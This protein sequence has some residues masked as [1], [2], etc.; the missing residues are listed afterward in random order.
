M[1]TVVCL[2]VGAANGRGA[3][4]S[5][6][7]ARRARAELGPEVWSEVIRIENAAHGSAYPRM[8]HALVFELAD[9]L[10][11]Y[12]S[13]DGTQSL[14]LRRGQVAEDKTNLTPLLHAIERGFAR[15]TIVPDEFSPRPPEWRGELPNGCF[16]ESVAALRTR[17]ERGETVA[18]AQLLSYYIDTGDGPH[19]HTVLTYAQGRAIEVID[20]AEPGPARQFPPAVA[21][22]A[23][24]LARALA[25]EQV[26]KARWLSLDRVA[27]SGG[28]FAAGGLAGGGDLGDATA[29]QQ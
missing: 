26:S 27:P 5:L 15:W 9:I 3:D 2:L 11:F 13:C 12:T 19:G 1:I 8:F 28:I 21:D 7:A 6:A 18:D 29:W 24:K 17:R 25:G 23:L 22:D 20:P 4:S 16:I 14:S 10:W